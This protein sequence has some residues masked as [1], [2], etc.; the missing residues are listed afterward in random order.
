MVQKMQKNNK[1][2][3]KNTKKCDQ[4]RQN[5]KNGVYTQMI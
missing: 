1:K 4:K 5:G 3:T 2:I